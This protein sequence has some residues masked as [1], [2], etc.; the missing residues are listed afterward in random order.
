VLRTYRPR[1]GG[2]IPVLQKVQAILGYLPPVVQNY[3]ALGLGISAASVYG[4]TSFYSFFTMTPRGRHIV[5]VCLGTACYVVGAGRLIE[6]LKEHLDVEVGGTTAD[7]MFSLEG[8]R[9]VGACGLAPVVMVDH[10]THG[11]VTFEK[12]VRSSRY[13]GEETAAGRW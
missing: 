4:V 1:P 12:T 10:D 6:K 7:R 9:C 8:V 2:L 11:C 3:I 5:R 13:K